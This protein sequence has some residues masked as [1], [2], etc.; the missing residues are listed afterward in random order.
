MFIKLEA[1]MEGCPNSGYV[2][3]I[4]NSRNFSMV[5]QGDTPE[6]ATKELIKSLKVSISYVFGADINSISEREVSDREY[7]E[8]LSALRDTGKKE[9]K[10]QLATA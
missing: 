8:L 2:A 7:S 9:L 3:W 1:H 5:V 10:F 4:E 6:N